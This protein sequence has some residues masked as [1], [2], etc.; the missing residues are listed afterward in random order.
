MIKWIMM[1]LSAILFFK[2]SILLI[3]P[4]LF[5]KFAN[6]FGEKTKIQNKNLKFFVSILAGLLL[7]LGLFWAALL[8][9][10]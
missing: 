6:L 3:S 2:M 10:I 9:S 7:A 4:K 5:N 8:T 1:S